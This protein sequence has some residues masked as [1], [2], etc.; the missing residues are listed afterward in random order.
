[1]DR[2]RVG[3]AVIHRVEEWRG[4]VHDAADP[5]RRL[6]RRGLRREQTHRRRVLISTA[7]TDAIDARLQSWVVEVGG[8]RVLIDTGAGND[9]MRP[10]IPLFGHPADPV[11]RAPCDRRL[12]AGRHR[13]RHLHPFARRPRRLE[14]AAGQ[15][16]LG[17]DVPERTLRVPACGCRVLGSAQSRSLCA[18]D[19]RGGQCRLLRGQRAADPRARPRRTRRR[20]VRRV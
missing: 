4:H 2:I 9:K 8:L 17:A 1:M 11:P 15:R 7:T 14:H 6:L 18:Q 13:P 16:R 12:H 20:T 5:V 3:D 10:G 19:R